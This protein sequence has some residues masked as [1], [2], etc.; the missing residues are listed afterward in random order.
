MFIIRISL[1][2]SFHILFQ[3][4][5]QSINIVLW[6]NCKFLYLNIPYLE[7][8]LDLSSHQKNF[9]IPFYYNLNL[10]ILYHKDILQ[11][12]Q[13]P[14]DHYKLYQHFQQVAFQYSIYHDHCN[15]LSKVLFHMLTLQNLH[16]IY[17][18]LYLYHKYLDY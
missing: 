13:H 5:L 2:R 3:C 8:Y 9:Y 16:Y 7:H 11:T 14:K 1:Q 12:F 18:V 6:C 4:T 17:K 15:H 10:Y